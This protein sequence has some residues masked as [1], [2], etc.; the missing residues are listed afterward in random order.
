MKKN[1]LIKA[2]TVVIVAV[3]LGLVSYQFK[4]NREERK[5][6][7]SST[8]KKLLISDRAAGPS[9]NLTPAEQEVK[10]DK[11]VKLLSNEVSQITDN[12]EGINRKLDSE[13]ADLN[14]DKI[15]H[16]NRI[17]RANNSSDISMDEKALAVELLVRSSSQQAQETLKDFILAEDTT[18]ASQN[19]ALTIDQRILK[20]RAVEGLNQPT[21]L[22]EVIAKTGDS[23][24]SD[25]AHRA[26]LSRKGLSSTPEQQDLDALNKILS[27]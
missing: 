20:M 17:I 26:L 12:P 1:F 10:F 15:K 16:L 22:N 19:P 3:G 21:I 5:N 14:N 25:R 9:S 18:T 23:L 24:V 6:R 8:T 27:R 11:T 4:Q 13:A 7:M 2:L